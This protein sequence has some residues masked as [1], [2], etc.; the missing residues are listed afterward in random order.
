MAPTAIIVSR[1]TS[2]ISGCTST[3]CSSLLIYIL[4]S[5]RKHKLS[6]PA[7]RF[8]LAMSVVDV[9]QSL[10]YAFSSLPVPKDSGLHGAFGNDM[11]CSIQ[12]FVIQF[13]LGVPCYNASLCVWYLMSIKYNMHANDFSK[14]FEPFCHIVSML[15]PLTTAIV[16]AALDKYEPTGAVIC[17]LGNVKSSLLFIILISGGSFVAVSTIVIFYSL[18]CVVAAMM[19]IERKLRVRG[20]SGL[21]FNSFHFPDRKDALCQA[22]LFSG[23]FFLTFIFP[24]LNIL[25]FFGHNQD[26]PD[27]YSPLEVPQSIFL[28]LQGLWNFVI[29]VRRAVRRIRGD[30]PE[31][32]FGKAFWQ[33]LF[34][35]DEVQPPRRQRRRSSVRRSSFSAR[36]ATAIAAAANEVNNSEANI[37][38]HLE[39]DSPSSRHS[40]FSALTAVAIA[41]SAAADL[42]KN[43][44]S[45]LSDHLGGDSLHTIQ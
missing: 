20:E 43:S 28:P 15:G 41:P 9:F 24:T 14:Q 18:I 29:Y 10:G 31:L 25:L 16:C 1:F 11:T 30:Y 37:S 33:L 36:N 22:F 21:E 26:D 44:E 17:W 6:Q 7:N 38:D 13:G 42:K 27:S 2:A 19:S 39:S 3:I 32:S 40:S 12:G 45:N 8:L 5:D 23:A 35:P 4:V 34:R